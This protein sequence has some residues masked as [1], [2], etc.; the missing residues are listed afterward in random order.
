MRPG[1]FDPIGSV[2]E[3]SVYLVFHMGIVL[4]SPVS[5]HGIAANFAA[6]APVE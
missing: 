6:S 3:C 4:Y 5:F 1:R 2:P